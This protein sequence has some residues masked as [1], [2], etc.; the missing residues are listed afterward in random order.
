MIFVLL[1]A[2]APGVSFEQAAAC[3]AFV[4]RGRPAPQPQWIGCMP[5]LLEIAMPADHRSHAN[6]LQ[7]ASQH[8]HPLTVCADERGIEQDVTA[9]MAEQTCVSKMYPT[10]RSVALS[11]LRST[12]LRPLQRTS[13]CSVSSCPPIGDIA[14]QVVLARIS[15]KKESR[16]IATR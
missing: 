16:P 11:K 12:C 7:C 13:P 15:V 2:L 6:Q 4:G 9:C 14:S 8:L 1:H 5:M 3:T 10:S